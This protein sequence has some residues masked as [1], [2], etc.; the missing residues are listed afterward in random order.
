MLPGSSSPDSNRLAQEGWIADYPPWFWSFLIK[1][2]K[3]ETEEQRSHLLHLLRSM[4]DGK[5]EETQR[6]LSGMDPN[7]RLATEGE[8]TE[9]LLEW[10]IKKARH[11]NCIRLLISAGA[12][13]KEPNVAWKAVTYGGTD[14]LREVLKAGAN[15]NTG[16]DGE[17]PLTSA[18]SKDPE[19]VRL[20]LAAG[21]RTDAT[22]TIYI[23]NKK[24]VTRVTPLMVAAYGGEVQ[25]AK[26]LLEAGADIDAVDAAG[27]NALSWAKISRSRARAAKISLLIQE[28]GAK[29]GADAGNLPEPVDFGARAKSPEFRKAVELARTLTKSPSKPVEL[30]EGPLPGAHAFRISDPGSAATLLEEIR[31]KATFLGAL[32]FL[33]ENLYEASIPYLVMVPTTDYR[34]AIVAFETPEGQSMDSY[35]LIA[36]LNELEKTQPFIITH[37]APDTFRARFTGPLKDPVRIAKAVQTICPDAINASIADI[38]KQLVKSQELSLWWD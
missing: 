18:C 6:L 3:C 10:A 38:A 11:P 35:D 7:L 20:L 12:S 30:A 5:P 21:A 36:W 34:E 22:T 37:L 8:Q 19:A 13:L 16:P 9:S 1:P 4:E 27:N 29:P 25:I 31:P 32:S 15:P 33:S 2:A 17:S 14:L 23:T 26:L 28:A 24:R